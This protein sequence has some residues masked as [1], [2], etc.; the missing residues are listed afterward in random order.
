MSCKQ[1]P[2]SHSSDVGKYRSPS[3]LLVCLAA[4]LVGLASKECMNRMASF[5]RVFSKSS[6]VA[7]DNLKEKRDHQ[8]LM[9]SAPLRLESMPFPIH[10]QLVRFSLGDH[11]LARQ[12]PLVIKFA[13]F[14]HSHLYPHLSGS[15]RLKPNKQV[16]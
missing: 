10:D 11:Q 15:T 14:H 2:T 9:H 3:R 5:G 6:L 16:S 1:L 4:S 7:D 12:L 13:N 8:L